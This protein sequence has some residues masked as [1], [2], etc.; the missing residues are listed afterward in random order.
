MSED[1]PDEDET[2]TLSGTTLRVY[3]YMF[4]SG[5]SLG[6]HEV[7][8][9]MDLSSSSVAQYHI[10][11]LE[12]AG[13]VSKDQNSRYF[14][15]RAVFENMVRIRRSLIPL[16]TAYAV[17]FGSGLALLLLLFRPPM[18]TG[19]YLFAVILVGLACA[20]FSY[21]ALRAAK[22]SEL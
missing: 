5:K 17:S 4:R 11:K 20:I 19:G 21:Q 14:V 9:A 16:Q 1:R 15:N 12:N 18:L 2:F 8:H 22:R 10:R 7:Q 3:R 13:L 6:I